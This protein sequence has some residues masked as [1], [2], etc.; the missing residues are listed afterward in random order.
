MISGAFCVISIS[1]EH[2]V[3][4]SFFS[5]RYDIDTIWGFFSRYDT[6]WYDMRASKKTFFLRNFW[7]IFRIFGEFSANFQ[8]FRRIFRNF[9][10]FSEFS[11]NFRNFRRIFGISREFS[12]FSAEKDK[13]KA[14]RGHI[15]ILD[16]GGSIRYTLRYTKKSDIS[17]FD[18]FPIR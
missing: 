12:D 8:N 3:A 16:M 1:S 6:I 11:E 2:W 14:Y 10:E 13:I 18:K 15:E 9:C 17:A 4:I 7:R 5:I